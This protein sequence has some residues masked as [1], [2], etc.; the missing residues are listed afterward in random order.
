MVIDVV[1]SERRPREFLQQ[2]IFFIRRAVG[3]NDAD[4]FTAT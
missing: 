3:A 2:I 4:S 1:G